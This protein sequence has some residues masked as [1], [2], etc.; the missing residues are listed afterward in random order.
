MRIPIMTAVLL[1]LM[2]LAVDV[3]IFF[4]IRSFAARARRHLYC[5]IYGVS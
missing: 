5:W 1:M 3:Y 4:D 2:S